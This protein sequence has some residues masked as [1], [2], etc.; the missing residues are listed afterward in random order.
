MAAKGRVLRDWGQ[1][2]GA[3]V[4]SEEQGSSLM[5]DLKLMSRVTTGAAFLYS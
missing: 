4:H 5:L 3:V 1:G 2:R